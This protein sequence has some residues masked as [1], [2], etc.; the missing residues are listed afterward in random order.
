MT[1]TNLDLPSPQRLKEP[2]YTGP[3]D[4]YRNLRFQDLSKRSPQPMPA[5]ENVFLSL[6][7]PEYQQQ[8]NR[9]Q[10]LSSEINAGR[11]ALVEQLGRPDSFQFNADK[12]WRSIWHKVRHSLGALVSPKLSASELRSS[13][14]AEEARLG[15]KLLATP[16]PEGAR[17]EFFALG[18]DWVWIEDTGAGEIVT[19]RYQIATS[20]EY[21]AVIKRQ[22]NQPQKVLLP[23]DSEF[24]QLYQAAQAYAREVRGYYATLASSDGHIS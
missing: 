12:G 17:R 14:I 20:Q 4:S 9:L 16:P 6:K 15:G 21:L 22:D 18:L 5:P 24:D 19:T 8:I 10:T 1:T 2:S 11:E 7:N 23:G 13:L 3:D